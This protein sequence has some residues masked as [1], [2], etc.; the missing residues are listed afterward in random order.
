MLQIC[1]M[2]FLMNKS[3]IT[4]F[5][6]IY[7]RTQGFEPATIAKHRNLMDPIKIF[8]IPNYIIL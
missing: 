1:N 2:L 4:Q 7:L 3:E 5:N 6:Q 8:K